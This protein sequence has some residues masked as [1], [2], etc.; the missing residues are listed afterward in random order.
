MHTI[1]FFASYFS[2]KDIPY[3]IMVYLV[4][5]KKH[6]TE[7]VLLSSQKQ[8]TNSSLAFLKDEQIQLSVED[9]EGFDFGL[10]QKAFQKYNVST[11]DR[12]ALVNDSCILFKPLNELMTWVSLNDA[13]MQGIT[14]SEAI[15]PHLQS[16]FL[17][18]NS[19]AIPLAKNYFNQ[20]TLLNNIKDVITTYEIGLSSHIIRNNL[21]IAAF[22][23]NDN[24]HGEFSPYYYCIAYHLKKGIPTIKKKIL[25][26]SYRKD[27]LFTLA[28]MN[29]NISVD[30]YLELIKKYNTTT[31]I[32]FKLLQQD[33]VGKIN[34]FLK[35]K[36]EL[37]RYLIIVKRRC[38][39]K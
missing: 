11:F 29:F 10:W 13:D 28:R 32:N 8:L 37:T 17:I 35:L 34:L 36:Y 33:V 15:A 2:Q 31:I 7:V 12:I 6:F 21:K 4:E 38:T 27:E 39:R 23:D 9:N 3:Y 16:Y 22:I 30:F 24:Y 25:F 26:S 18:L 1:C 14:K 19:K 5:L 20:H